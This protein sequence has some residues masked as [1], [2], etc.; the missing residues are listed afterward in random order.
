L[1]IA[2]CRQE[3]P[4][5][6]ASATLV[7]VGAQGGRSIAAGG[8]A[9][10]G[11]SRSLLGEQ[12]AWLCALRAL[13]LPFDRF[14]L[15]AEGIEAAP[16]SSPMAT[17]NLAAVARGLW[18]PR[19]WHLVVLVRRVEAVAGELAAVVADPTGEALA[20][21]DGSVAATWPQ[22][23]VEGSVL[24]LTNVVALPALAQ[25]TKAS[26]QASAHLDLP[27]LLVVARAL[28]RCFSAAGEGC[29]AS[30]EEAAALLCEARLR[31]GGG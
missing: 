2:R 30:P 27:R 15:G 22:A 26:A 11:G 13:N 10:S 9:T 14:H 6:P 12:V 7:A 19:R 8:H 16:P 5:G 24:L 28:G 1:L 21:F 4:P 25:A 23:A 17:H 3:G 20:T 18:P 31:L 29:G